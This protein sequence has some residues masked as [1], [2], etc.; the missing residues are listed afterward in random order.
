[1]AMYNGNGIYLTLDGLDVSSKFTEVNIDNSAEAV[2][3]TTGNA[4]FM[5]R[6][7]GL[8]DHTAKITLGYDTSNV[9]TM[10][11]KL[12]PG[13]TY[14]VDYGPEG[15]TAGKPRH[16]ASFLLTSTSGPSTTTNKQFVKFE[17]TLEGNGTPT[18]DMYAGATF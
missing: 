11:L 10:I 12:K 8:R 18:N 9:A 14:V 17:L 1:M 6:N 15:S 2:D 16:T 4:T 13:L 5:A 3:V 7:A